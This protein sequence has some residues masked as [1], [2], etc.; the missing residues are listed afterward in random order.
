VG[1][2]QVPIIGNPATRKVM[3]IC[4]SGFSAFHCPNMVKSVVGSRGA[5]HFACAANSARSGGSAS[6][7]L[8]AS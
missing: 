2:D 5:S 1:V 6:I 3:V 8:A 7:A 4:M